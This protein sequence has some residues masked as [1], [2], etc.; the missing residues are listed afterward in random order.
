MRTE[1]NEG[2]GILDLKGV[3]FYKFSVNGYQVLGTR[4][5]VWGTKMNKMSSLSKM[6][7]LLIG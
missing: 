6:G 1:Q 4:N 2:R 3:Q 7:V 5:N